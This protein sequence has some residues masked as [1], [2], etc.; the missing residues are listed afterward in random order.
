MG[1]GIGMGGRG[2]RHLV[3]N[4]GGDWRRWQDGGVK[5]GEMREVEL[6]VEREVGREIG[7]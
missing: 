4:L 3:R 7:D 1:I 5:E 6:E 2:G